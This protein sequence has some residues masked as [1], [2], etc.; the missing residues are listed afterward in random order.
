MQGLEGI[1]VLIAG[2]GLTML[3]E[4]KPGSRSKTRSYRS[5]FGGYILSLTT[6]RRIGVRVLRRIVYR[7]GYQH[8]MSYAVASQLVR[9]DLT[10]L[11]PVT[12]EQSSEEALGCLPISACLQEYINDSAVLIHGTPQILLL[13]LDLHEPLV[14]EKRIP[15]TPVGAA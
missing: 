2:H 14:E 11:I 4:S 12:F 5:L 3:L 6:G 15:V 7:L 10:W 8:A 13:A 1:L 9:H